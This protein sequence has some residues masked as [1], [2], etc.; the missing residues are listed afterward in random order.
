MLRPPPAGGPA[1]NAL[2]R[3]T[4]A[5][6]RRDGPDGYLHRKARHPSVCA[7]RRIQLPLQGSLFKRQLP[8][9]ASPVRGGAAAGGGG[10]RRL[11]R[12][13]PP[14]AW[15]ACTAAFAG[16]DACIVPP[17]LAECAQ[18][19]F[20]AGCCFVPFAG[21]SRIVGRAFTPAGEVCG[22]PEG[23]W[24]GKAPHPSVGWRRQLP[25][26][27]SLSNGRL[28]IKP[29]LQG[30]AE[31]SAACGGY[32][33]TEQVQRSQ[34]TSVLQ[35]APCDAGTANRTVDAPQGADGGVHCRLAAEISCKVGQD[36]VPVP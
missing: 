9:K 12:P 10:V 32:S 24:Q 27:G 18:G 8:I 35:R 5:A 19:S 15:Q 13:L 25:L 6:R 34:S 14:A 2:C 20:A 4:G 16:D 23:Y 17:T 28:S 22:G 11:A 21:K 1:Q 36:L 31:S 33:E 3:E 7:L 30:A 29:P 26:Q